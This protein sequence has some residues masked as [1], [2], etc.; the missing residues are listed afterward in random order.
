MS[1]HRGVIKSDL[2]RLFLND[3]RLFQSYSKKKWKVENN[4]SD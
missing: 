4:K 2:I 3:S 1:P